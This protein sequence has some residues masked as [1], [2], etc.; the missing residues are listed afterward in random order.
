MKKDNDNTMFYGASPTIFKY[1]EELRKNQTLSEEILWNELKGKKLGVKF[2]RQHPI[3]KYIADFYCHEKKL[4]IELD[5]EYHLDSDQKDY[6]K[7]RSGD[8]KEFGI[9]VIRFTNDEITTELENVI[10]KIKQ[11]IANASPN[12]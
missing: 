6:D 4:V 8:L 3:Y 7:Y 9:Q 5:G 10:T 12:A 11:K 2:R 1:A